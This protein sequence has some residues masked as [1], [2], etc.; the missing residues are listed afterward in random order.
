MKKTDADTIVKFLQ[1]ATENYGF[2]LQV[3]TN[4]LGETLIHVFSDGGRHI[5]VDQT[6][7]MRFVWQDGDNVGTET[8][9]ADVWSEILTR[10]I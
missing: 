6:E 3:K 7:P 4:V 5:I 1:P 2:D 8:N 9:V 10:L